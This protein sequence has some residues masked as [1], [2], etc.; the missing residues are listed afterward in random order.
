MS[1]GAG[2]DVDGTLDARGR[3]VLIRNVVFDIGQVF[4]RL[5]HRPFLELLAERGVDVSNLDG[6]LSKIAFEDH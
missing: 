6:L 5:N 2:T 1:G 3:T 4:L